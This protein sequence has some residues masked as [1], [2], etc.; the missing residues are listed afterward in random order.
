MP[1]ILA[2]DIGTTSTRAVIFDDDNQIIACHSEAVTLASPQACHEEQDAIELINK[3]ICC[4]QHCLK[5]SKLT[6]KD[7]TAIGI[8][9][10]RETIVAWDSQTSQPIYPAI[11]WKDS[12]TQSWCDENKASYEGKQLQQ[13]NGCPLSPYFSAPKINWLLSHCKQADNLLAQNKLRIGTLDCFLLWH[14]TG[15]STYATDISNASRTALLDCKQGSWDKDCLSFF[16]IPENLLPSILKTADTFGETTKELFGNPIPICGMLGDQQAAL[17]GQNC[18]EPGMSKCTYGTGLFVMTNT[19]TKFLPKDNL[20]ATV[21]YEVGDK[22]TY[23]LEGGGFSAASML[24]WLQKNF[25]LFE[26]PKDIDTLINTT[27][28]NLGVYLIPAFSG[29]GAPYWTERVGAE[30]GGLTLATEGPHILRATLE[31]IANQSWDIC[32]AMGALS[33]VR[34]DGGVANNDWICQY[35]A[36]IANTTI[37]R[38]KNAQWMTALGA[39]QMARLGAGLTM[40]QHGQAMDDFTPSS[41]RNKHC[42]SYAQWKKQ[43]GRYVT[44]EESQ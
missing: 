8:T 6:A 29:L 27:E 18:L 26:N 7:I 11:V 28:S 15:G 32:Q 2:L 14:L 21:A 35:L 39:A 5:K 25:G 38:P 34:V 33:A 40:Q 42:D 24:N 44:A 20:I 13:I 23:G 36:D 3:T 41:K 22:R 17:V 37:T 16:A 4:A 9:N 43:I 31:A 12:R 1:L 30:L 19:T 10:Q